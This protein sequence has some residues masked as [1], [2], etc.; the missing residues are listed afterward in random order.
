MQFEWDENKR[1]SNLESKGL[2]F[3]QAWQVYESQNKITL[4]SP[5]PDEE[6][7]MDMAEINGRVAV[8]V[9]TYR[10][11]HVRCISFRYAKSKER[12]IYDHARQAHQPLQH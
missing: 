2:D 10:N 4:Q 5:Y 3:R 7:L 12:R 1:R 8:L 6:R 9:Y 11:D